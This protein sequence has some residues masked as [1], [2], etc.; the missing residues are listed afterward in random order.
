MRAE[1][2]ENRVWMEGG[3]GDRGDGD[4]FNNLTMK[5]K[6]NVKTKENL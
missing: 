2:R 4:I 5:I 1:E 6:Y 3:G